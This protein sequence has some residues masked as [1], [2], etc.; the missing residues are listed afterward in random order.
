MEIIIQEI[1]FLS[2]ETAM[3]RRP[4]FAA[5]IAENSR[6]METIRLTAAENRDFFVREFFR[7]VIFT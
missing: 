4:H 6:I 1:C 5:G 3:H 2:S 7:E